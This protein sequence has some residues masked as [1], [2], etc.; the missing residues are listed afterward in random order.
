MRLFRYLMASL[1]CISPSLFVFADAGQLLEKTGSVT[2]GPIS[3]MSGIVKSKQYDDVYWVHNDSGDKSRLFALDAN[4]KVIIP[5]FMQGDYAS[6]SMQHVK[7]EANS[8]KKGWPGNTIEAASNI[9]WED[10]TTDGDMLYVADM[11]NNGNARRDLGV[12]VI[13][14]PNPTATKDI[15]ALKFLPVRFPEQQRYPAQ[16]WHYDTESIFHSDGSLYFISKHRQ[17]GKIDGWEQG[18]V[19]YRLDSEFTDRYNLL[20]EVEK[21]DEIL[22]A[23]G[24]D[25]SP[26]GRHLAI[27]CYTD[28]WIFSK[29]KIGDRWLSAPARRLSL[30]YKQ[31]KTSEA[32]TWV[33]DHTLVLGNE[34]RDLF[35]VSISDIPVF[36]SG[37]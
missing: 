33:D 23:T 18:A 25:L 22:L 8:K 17:P 13:P 5:P 3:E 16:N 2:F 10:I 29:P 30:D 12:Y 4:W 34:E 15:R 28:V 36:I 24:A 37:K 11:G 26:D 21:S 6:T 20:T 27:I 32:V 35:T 9:D 19:L 31:M 14:E 1:C 7:S